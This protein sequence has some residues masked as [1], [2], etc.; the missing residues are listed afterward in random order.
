MSLHYLVE[1]FSTTSC[2]WL[3]PPGEGP[4]LQARISVSDALKRREM[5]E[6]FILWYFDSFL[7]LLLKVRTTFLDW[8]W[9]TS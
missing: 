5:L 7:L 4:S 2:D 6:E 8:N 3:I 1:G 9:L